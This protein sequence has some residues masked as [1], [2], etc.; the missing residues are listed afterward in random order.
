MD[1][2]KWFEIMAVYYFFI[3]MLT[4]FVLMI[5]AFAFRNTF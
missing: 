1:N 3:G 5:L 4:M 2:D